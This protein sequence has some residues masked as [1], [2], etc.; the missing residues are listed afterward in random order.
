MARY[1]MMRWQDA[2]WP[3]NPFAMALAHSLSKSQNFLCHQ[4]SQMLFW[5]DSRLK[6]AGSL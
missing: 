4:G 1:T 5:A 6:T 2:A 3:Q